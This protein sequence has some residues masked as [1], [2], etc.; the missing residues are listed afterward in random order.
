VSAEPSPN[1]CGVH[2]LADGRRIAWREYG[3]PRGAPV[4]W[5]HGGLVL[6]RDVSPADGPARELGLR[7]VAPDRPGIGDSD[8][9]LGRDT[10]MWAAD[11]TDLLGWSLGGEYALAFGA[12]LAPR[13]TRVGV[14]AGT[15]S[16]N[17]PT[18]FAQLN[19]LDRAF[20]R[21]CARSAPAGT[22]MFAAVRLTARARPAT[23]ERRSA[24]GLGAADAA[25]M[26]RLPPGS[27]AAWNAAA[28]AHPRGMV[29]EY[30]AMLRPWGFTLGEVAVPVDLWQGDLDH[31]VPARWAHRLAEQLPD[32][33]LHFVRG[34][35]HFLA[36]DHWS[37]VLKPFA[38]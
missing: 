35:G 30:R 19:N 3:D 15:L 12:R 24:K 36:Y 21:V 8:P 5:N 20:S 32:A 1:R 27:F 9:Q 4:L 33:T 38:A 17:D 22:A 31:M 16:M 28:M 6:G 18:A 23:Y 2:T 13:V 26:A 10:V 7:I 14:V 34:A 11:A 25:V 37:E 29:E